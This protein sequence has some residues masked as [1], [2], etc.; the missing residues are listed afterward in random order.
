MGD[1]IK[2]KLKEDKTSARI[3]QNIQENLRGKDSNLP[4]V[5]SSKK[6]LMRGLHDA[7]MP[8][9]SYQQPPR[10]IELEASVK[11][12]NDGQK[13]LEKIRKMD[14]STFYRGI[15]HISDA[16]L[17]LFGAKPTKTDV[18]ELFRTQQSNVREL[19]LI[20]AQMVATYNKDVKSTRSGLDNLIQTVTDET[21]KRQS[22]DKELPPEI[23][24]Y[25]AAISN[26]GELD[27]YKDKEP[28]KFYSALQEVIDSKRVS[29]KKRFE[30]VIT[31]MGQEHHREQI[32]N[33]MMQ[34][35][36]FETMLYRVME[37]A[38]KT[39]LYQQTLDHNTSIWENI[40]QLSIA[41][42]R[43][44]GGIGVLSDFNKQLNESYISAVGEISQIVDRHPGGALVAGTNRELRQL[45][46]DV[47][48]SAYRDAV[49][50]ERLL[51]NETEW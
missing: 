27:Q 20:L 9:Q 36:L 23:Q 42:N 33:L 24:R 15:V 35:E 7:G 22:L 34:E 5:A 17:G 45:V 44:S 26:L 10:V 46:A 19:N 2:A 25:E 28:G 11:R 49:Q 48:S 40:Q 13:H 51:P 43:V 41:V 8:I 14:N 32:D 30:Y 31:A 6:S 37:M 39:E 47:N 16:F 38:A 3:R 50:Y 18:Y 12:I 29:R 21:M 4:V 1:P